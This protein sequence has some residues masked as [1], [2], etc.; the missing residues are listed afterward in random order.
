MPSKERSEEMFSRVRLMADGDPQWDLSDNDTAAL[1]HVL[2]E[3]EAREATQPTAA[4]VIEACE[5]A[6][7]TIADPIEC[8]CK[9]CTGDC[10]SIAA[11]AIYFEG[12]Q[13]VAA[14][15][16]AVIARWKEAK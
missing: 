3:A 14:D 10:Q 4:E 8:G 15:A 13:E 16:L 12:Q 6:L 9:P 1:R 2:A 5:K 7:A 11:K